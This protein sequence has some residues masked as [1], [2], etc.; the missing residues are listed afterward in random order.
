M[1]DEKKTRRGRS[2]PKPGPIS[3]AAA[4]TAGGA[5]AA[6]PAIAEL[7]LVEIV[8]FEFTAD[9]F[10]FADSQGETEDVIKYARDALR[11]LADWAEAMGDLFGDIDQALRMAGD[12]RIL[13]H[14]P[15]WSS[16]FEARERVR[17]NLGADL[18]AHVWSEKDSSRRGGA[19]TDQKT[20]DAVE[21]LRIYLRMLWTWR[22]TF[23][24]GLW[25]A[26]IAARGSIESDPHRRLLQGL[27][28]IAAVCEFDPVDPPDRIHSELLGIAKH[29]FALISDPSEK[30]AFTAEITSAIGKANAALEF[31]SV[32]SGTA[33][34]VKP[35]LLTDWARRL[36]DQ[37]TPLQREDRLAPEQWA[38]LESAYWRQW[39]WSVTAPA[40]RRQLSTIS[41]RMAVL[42]LMVAAR[43]D[44]E[45]FLSWRGGLLSIPQWSRILAIAS[46][47]RLELM[48]APAEAA[49]GQLGFSELIIK[50]LSPGAEKSAPSRSSQRVAPPLVALSIFSKDSALLQWRPDPAVRAF[51][52]PHRQRYEAD[53]RIAHYGSEVSSVG[54]SLL[55]DVIARSNEERDVAKL[56]LIEVAPGQDIGKITDTMSRFAR[57]LGWS[58]VYFGAEEPPLDASRPLHSSARNIRELAQ[59]VRDKFSELFPDEFI[60]TWAGLYRAVYRRFQRTDAYAVMRRWPAFEWLESRLA[61]PV[62]QKGS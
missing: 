42:D 48:R 53:Q 4:A 23:E 13:P 46:P 27:G 20:R 25:I 21:E 60:P 39:N 17:D 18:E 8:K 19:L 38:A 45:T 59:E 2:Q 1:A 37:L 10:G 40:A 29:A 16:T 54:P 31:R 11:A 9:R 12:A 50:P 3:L 35:A 44:G 5:E 43:Y 33:F 41:G 22:K 32:D 57:G 7:R 34:V 26:M 56:H 58:R 15:T 55:A 28:A 36:R 62:K 30:S 51:A 47:E 49:L 52:L 14:N 61:P 24:A 6:Q